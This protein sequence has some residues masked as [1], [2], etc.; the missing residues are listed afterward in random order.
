M[1]KLAICLFTSCFLYVTLREKTWWK[2]LIPLKNMPIEFPTHPS[3]CPA[4]VWQRARATP[5]DAPSLYSCKWRAWTRG[6]WGPRRRRSWWG[7]AAWCAFTILQFYT[8]AHTKIFE[9]QK[10]KTC[11]FMHWKA[12]NNHFS[13]LLFTFFTL[14]LFLEKWFFHFFHFQFR[15]CK[16]IFS[17]SLSLLKSEKITFPLFKE[18]S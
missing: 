6:H 12:K 4:F 10:K 11:V 18:K 7:R 5:R 16:L 9:K 15:F 14:R 3:P 2:T 8:H 1:K 13:L 17:L